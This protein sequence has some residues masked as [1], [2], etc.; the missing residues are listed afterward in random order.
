MRAW[1]TSGAIRLIA[2]TDDETGLLRELPNRV[3]KAMEYVCK[4]EGHRKGKSEI[5]LTEVKDVSTT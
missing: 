3:F 1:V 2:D 5:Y 4:S